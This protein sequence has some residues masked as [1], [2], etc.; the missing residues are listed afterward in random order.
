MHQWRAPRAADFLIHCWDADGV[1]YDMTSGDTHARTLA[2]LEEHAYFGAAPGQ[3]TLIKQEGARPSAPAGQGRKLQGSMGLPGPL[4]VLDIAP[5]TTRCE[6][7]P[8][9]GWRAWRRRSSCQ[10]LNPKR[11]NVCKPEFGGARAPAFS[12]LGAP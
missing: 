11:R 2:L 5:R 7:G 12:A 10:D 8:S 6:P 1:L 4:L 9:G 3:I